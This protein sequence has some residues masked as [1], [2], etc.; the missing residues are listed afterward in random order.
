VL[1]RLR[2][3]YDL[4]ETSSSGA[5]PI[6]KLL[7]WG[8]SRAPYHMDVLRKATAMVSRQIAQ[9]G[10]VPVDCL[11]IQG[12]LHCCLAPLISGAGILNMVQMRSV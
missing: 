3:P 7:V 12:M 10:F 8:D 4:A 1:M 11:P 9:E 6:S 2:D 5:G